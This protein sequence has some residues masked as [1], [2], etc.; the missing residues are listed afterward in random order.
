MK[1]WNDK[2][3]KKG[4]MKKGSVMQWNKNKT[5]ERKEDKEN[6]GIKTMK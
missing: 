4:N 3:N 5:K 6:D 2:I 1:E